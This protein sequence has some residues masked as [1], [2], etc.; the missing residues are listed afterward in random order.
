LRVFSTRWFG[1]FAA[2]QNIS[3][4]Q[5][6]DAVQ[7]AENGSIESNLGGGLI[8]Q[9]VSRR[10]SGRSGGF[11]VVVAY[12]SGYRAVF[13]YGFAKNER[14]NITRVELEDLR[15]V[16]RAWLEADNL[17]ITAATADGAIHELRSE[18]D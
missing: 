1:R 18:D 5:L 2:S 6:L 12:R 7:G 17:A 13:V 4:A 11:R 8:K 3:N 10:G 14:E 9:R 16:G 15:R